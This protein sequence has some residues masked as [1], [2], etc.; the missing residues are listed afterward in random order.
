M[1]SYLKYVFNYLAPEFFLFFLLLLLLFLNELEKNVSS[2]TQKPSITATM[3]CKS[4]ANIYSPCKNLT[5]KE[6][7]GLRESGGGVGSVSV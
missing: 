7:E 6:V 4:T 5:N 2:M 1:G 3:L